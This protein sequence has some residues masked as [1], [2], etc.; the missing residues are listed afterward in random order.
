[1][2]RGRVIET[3]DHVELM[4]RKGF[5]YKLH[6]LQNGRGMGMTIDE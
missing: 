6:Q 2:H 3:G 1:L 5:Y 4:K